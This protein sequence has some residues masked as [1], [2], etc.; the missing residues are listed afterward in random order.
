M[1]FELRLQRKQAEQPV[2]EVKDPITDE[3]KRIGVYVIKGERFDRRL[4][5]IHESIKNRMEESSTYDGLSDEKKK[6][7]NQV[8]ITDQVVSDTTFPYG[9][10]MENKEY[11]APVDA[12]IDLMTVAQ[13]IIESDA[14]YDNAKLVSRDILANIRKLVGKTWSERDVV[15]DAPL[16]IHQTSPLGAGGNQIMDDDTKQALLEAQRLRVQKG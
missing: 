1:S 5:K 6:L 13:D 11:R 10:A 2:A 4:A 9:R 7:M 3:L 15:G 8:D 12:S 14:D 16:V